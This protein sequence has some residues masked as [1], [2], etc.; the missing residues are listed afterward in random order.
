MFCLLFDSGYV[1]AQSSHVRVLLDEARQHREMGQ[2]EQATKVV[3]LALSLAKDSGNDSDI[4]RAMIEQGELAGEQ[5][6]L[7]HA[8]EIFDHAQALLENTQDIQAKAK[9]L[10]AKA[11]NLRMQGQHP[12]ALILSQRALALYQSIGDELGI[13]DEFTAIGVSLEWQGVW[14][15]ALHAYGQ[16]LEI[17]QK[18]NDTVRLATSF[19]NIGEIHRDMGDQETALTYFQDALRLDID[20]GQPKNIAYSHTK[21]A[22]VLKDLGRIDEARQQVTLAQALFQQI[23][24]ERDALW[25]KLVLARIEFAAGNIPL[26]EQLLQEGLRGVQEKEVL[27]LNVNALLQLSELYLKQNNLELAKQHIEQGYLLASQQQSKEKL[28]DFEAFR[29]KLFAQQNDFHQAFLAQQKVQQL[30]DELLDTHRAESLARMQSQ[31]EFTRRAQEI[32]L[33]KKDQELQL[34]AAERE[35]FLWSLWIVALTSGFLVLF[36]AYGK[37]S[38]RR[39]TRQLSEQVAQRT[40]QLNSK[41]QELQEA[42]RQVEQASTTDPLTGLRNR[43]FL[44][45]NLQ[46]DLQRSLRLHQDHPQNDGN[47]DIDLLFFLVDLDDFKQVNDVHGHSAGD[48]VLQ[49]F[50]ALLQQVFRSSDYL[51][52]WGGEEFLVVSRFTNRR[53]AAE[54]AQRLL[55]TVLEYPFTL[56]DGTLLPKSCSIGYS[57]FPL[58][59]EHPQQV[60]WHQVL[61]AADASLYA[62]KSSGKHCWIGIEGVQPGYLPSPSEQ[63]AALARQDKLMTNASTDQVLWPSHPD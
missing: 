7:N 19:Y 24:A 59:P 33:L 28:A 2:I 62:A 40:A 32:A 54:L 49:Q 16:A 14:Q 41:N 60:S 4:G 51:V 37:Y 50:A 36:L 38:Q 56:S 57:C 63:W 43:R 13:A 9:V 15:D 39:L 30:K 61:E 31:A 44:E 6:D 5:G 34:T 42:Y 25:A 12:E 47:D 3:E 48:L 11:G 23:N 27:D 17:A 22:N 20:S 53:R 1:L 52:R 46:P 18:H 45:Q 26:A 8:M 10:G 55:D 58:M 35:R 21:V 29:V